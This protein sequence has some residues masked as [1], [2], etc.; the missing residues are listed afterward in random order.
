MKSFKEVR[1]QVSEEYYSG[2]T[3]Y[4]GGDTTNVGDIAG[5]NLGA[6]ANGSRPTQYGSEKNLAEIIGGLNVALSGTKLDPVDSLTR[7][8][9]KLNMTGFN[10][11]IDPKAIRMAATE[12]E[13]YQVPLMFMDRVVGE[14]VPPEDMAGNGEIGDEGKVPYEQTLPK[15]KLSFAFMPSGTGYRITATIMK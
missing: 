15:S 11:E 5:S 4:A 8:R 2:P 9:A 1:Q 13:M 12:G 3:A 7:A 14:E 6:F 10:F